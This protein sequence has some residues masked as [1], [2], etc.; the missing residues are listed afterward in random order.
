[1]RISDWSSD[2]CSSDLRGRLALTCWK[3]LLICSHRD[4][5]SGWMIEISSETYRHAYAIWL[6]TGSWPVA[7]HHGD[8]EVKF[9]PYHDPSNGQLPFEPGGSL[10]LSQVLFSPGRQA[11][12]P[13]E[14]VA[15]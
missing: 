11:P 3:M 12:T 2:V 9:N 15:P 5:K 13:T 14:R 8:I 6:R 4:S 10:Q 1:M 7:Q